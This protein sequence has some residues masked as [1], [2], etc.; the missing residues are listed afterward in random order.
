MNI[1]D[2][3]FTCKIHG[4]IIASS[5]LILALIS[6][7]DSYGIQKPVQDSCTSSRRNLLQAVKNVAIVAVSG[8]SVNFLSSASVNAATD[9]AECPPRSQNCIRTTWTAPTGTKDVTGTVL[10]LFKSYPMEGQN[11]I[12]KGGWTVAK[13]GTDDGVIRFEYK[14][15]IGNFAKFFNGGKPFVDDVAIQVTGNTIDIRSASRIGDSDL[16]VNQ[17]RLQFLVTKARDM[18][19]EAPDPKY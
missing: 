1:L 8:S 7:V 18:G 9:I 12:D 4:F 15:G 16:G 5:V 19:W 11:D 13:D 6:Q 17:K 3:I 2:G 14:S 10:D